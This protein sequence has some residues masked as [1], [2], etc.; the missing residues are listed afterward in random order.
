MA[1][2]DRDASRSAPRPGGRFWVRAA[3][4]VLAR[5]ALWPTALRQTLRLARPRW[6]SRPP[7]LPVPDRDYLRFRFE[8]QYGAGGRPDAHDLVAYLEWCRAG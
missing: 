1:A 3:L 4:L 8:T 6:W 2:G 7:F 5:P